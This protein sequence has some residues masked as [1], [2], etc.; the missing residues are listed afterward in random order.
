MR[1]RAGKIY[2][3]GK[4]TDGRW[5]R[6]CDGQIRRHARFGNHDNVEYV[7]TARSMT[8]AI[9]CDKKFE[10]VK[11]HQS[12]GFVHPLTCG[13]D[14]TH[15]E[16]VPV[17]VGPDVKLACMDCDWT[18]SIPSCVLDFAPHLNRAAAFLHRS[19]K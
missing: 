15:S 5:I 14:S 16:L 4:L 11:K 1:K 9:E 3:F 7:T 2:H 17:K 12:A 19:D 10:A 8:E 6:W 18:Q 13:N